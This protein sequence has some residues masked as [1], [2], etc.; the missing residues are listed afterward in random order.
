MGEDHDEFKKS[1]SSKSKTDDYKDFHV[2]YDADGNVEAVEF[3]DGSEITLS[4]KVI[5]P[6]ATDDIEGAIPGIKRSGNSFTDTEKS[7]G[8]EANSSNAK[9]ILVGAEGYY[10]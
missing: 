2:F 6:I 10:D 5:F 3:F 1:S 8:I 4:G 9:S 7:I